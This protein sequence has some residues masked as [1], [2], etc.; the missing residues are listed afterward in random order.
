MKKNKVF[1]FLALI[2]II[3]LAVPLSIIS[4]KEVATENGLQGKMKVEAVLYSALNDTLDFTISRYIEKD[5]SSGSYIPVYLDENGFV[6]GESRTS[7][8]PTGPYIDREKHRKHYLS[9]SFEKSLLDFIIPEDELNRL[10]LSRMSE[11]DYDDFYV[12]VS[13]YNGEIIFKELWE[14]DRKLVEFL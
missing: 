8:K 11:L 7:I 14:G 6:K 3:Q 13:I 10:T 9:H 1:I 12:T 5:G 2:F 4:M